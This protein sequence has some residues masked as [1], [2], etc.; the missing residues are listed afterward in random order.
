MREMAFRLL[1]LRY[2]PDLTTG[3]FLNVGVALVCPDANWWDV[4]LASQ[5]KH[6]SKVFPAA[7]TEALR[8]YLDRV[9]TDLQ[10]AAESR[11]QFDVL[12]DVFSELNRSVGHLIGA[13]RWSHDPIEGVTDD[14]EAELQHWYTRLVGASLHATPALGGARI[15]E[16]TAEATMRVALKARG[17]WGKLERVV[18]HSYR[19]HLF[20]Y[21]HRNGTLRVFQPI[22]LG[23]NEAKVLRSAD[24]W[25]GR[26]D[27]LSDA[28]SEP[29][30]FVP[31]IKLSDHSDG[32]HVGDLALRVLRNAKVT[33]QAFT[34]AQVEEFGDYVAQV[35][36]E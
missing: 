5:F 27:S 9:E 4:R 31:F 7:Q 15:V 1:P 35:V 24:I 17:V 26:I 22:N 28:P 2:Y 21:S 32:S 34:T 8:L 36:S 11:A 18:V 3:E 12:L 13:V 33:E 29:F 25:R 10:T 30:K 6:I 14:P 16:P 19:T 23:G 20:K